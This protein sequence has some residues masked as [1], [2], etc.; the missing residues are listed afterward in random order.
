MRCVWLSLKACVRFVAFH[1][2]ATVW[3]RALVRGGN[4]SKP[5][6]M[7]GQVTF[8]CLL[9]VRG[10]GLVTVPVALTVLLGIARFGRA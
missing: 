7:P 4:L 8:P 10:A 9:R 1:I 6:P 3:P 2:N 5:F